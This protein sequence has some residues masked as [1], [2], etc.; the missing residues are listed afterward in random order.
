[1]LAALG[2]LIAACGGD[3]DEPGPRHATP[4]TPS[5]VASPT[6]IPTAE[7][8]APTEFRVAFV[9]LHNPL[10]QESAEAPSFEDRLAILIQELKEFDADVVAFNEAFRT[11]DYNVITTLGEALAMEPVFARANPWFPDKSEEETKALLEEVGWQEGELLLVR[12][13]LY[14]VLTPGTSYA[15]SPLSSEAGERRIGLH[16]VIKGPPS[17]GEV[18][19]FVTHLKGGGDAVR[20]QQAQDFAAWVADQQGSGPSIVFVGQDDPASAS[21]YDAYRAI[22]LREVFSGD[23]VPTCCRASLA[24]EQPPLT[25]HNDYILYDRMQIAEA[26]LIGAEPTAL[27]DGTLV[28]ASDHNG[29]GAKFTIPP[30]RTPYLP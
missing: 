8:E 20:A 6:S 19:L 10:F 15:L 16:V 17:F 7:V 28:Y 24:G 25:A 26:I 12:S 5:P 21:N 11:T 22:G 27:E 30:D 4:E 18:D 9:N 3:T 13:S 2:L 23:Q 1:M 14:A 29:I